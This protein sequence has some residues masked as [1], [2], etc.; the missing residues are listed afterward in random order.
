MAETLNVA[1][2]IGLLQRRV[3]ELENRVAALEQKAAIVE[4]GFWSRIF[5]WN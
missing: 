4:R 5:G 1:E 2:A 3:N